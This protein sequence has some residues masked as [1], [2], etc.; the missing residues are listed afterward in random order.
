MQ[1]TKKSTY[2]LLFYLKRN[3]LKKNGNAPIMARITIDG[4]PKTMGTKLEIDPNIWDLK[5]GRV[6]G[7]ST[8][9]LSLNQK[10][11]NI[12]GRIDQIYEDMLKH[13]GFATAQKLKLA[14]LGVGVMED[15]LL[16]VFKKNNE[17]FGKMVAKGERSESTYY[18]YKIVYN[19]VAEFIKNRYHRDDMAF[20]ELTC[21]FIREFDFF[22]RI[23]KECSHNTVWVYTM[24]LYRVAELAVKNG[25]I[26]KNPFE[27]YEISMKENDRSY[28]LK[29]QVEALLM[30]SPSKSY[31][32]LVKDLFVFSC[33]TGLSYIDI[34]QLKNTNIQSFF[35]G[36]DWIISRRQKSDVTSNVRLMEIPKR[37]IEKYKNTTR[38]DFIFPV[39][40]NKVCNSYIDKLIQELGIVTEQKV[41]FHTARHTFGTMFLTEGVPLES[42]SKM[43]GHKNISTTQI[44]AK[45][46][47]Q[48]ISKDMDLVSDKFRSMENAFMESI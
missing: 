6:E 16:K 11:D 19:H 22:L 34:K 29:E 42:L 9:A 1:Q 20:R 28:L 2:K 8:K 25:L 24:P 43:M 14:F 38:N 3:E 44:Y 4:T 10:L 35:D 36:H 33:F 47:S 30:H 32:E 21:D 45:I 7:K 5:F 26:R 17:D 37:I 46:T 27:D 18:K 41:T 15:S 48:K 31:Y 12:R 39:P 40:T 13:E 23:D